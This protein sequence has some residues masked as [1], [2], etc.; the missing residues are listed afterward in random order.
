MD[1]KIIYEQD[2]CEHLGITIIM[3]YIYI[4]ND[5]AKQKVSGFYYGEPDLESLQKFK[6]KNFINNLE[7]LKNE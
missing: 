4:D 7:V 5:I 3:Q 6:D 2:Y 1:F